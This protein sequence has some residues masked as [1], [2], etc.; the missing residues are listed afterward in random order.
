MIYNQLTLDGQDNK[1]IIGRDVI[2]LTGSIKHSTMITD[3]AGTSSDDVGR[4]QKSIR[5]FTVLKG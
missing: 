5:Q 3:R 1:L 2:W 4:N